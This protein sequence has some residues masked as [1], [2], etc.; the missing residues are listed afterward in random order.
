MRDRVRKGRVFLLF[1]GLMLLI[2]CGRADAEENSQGSD[3]M[4]GVS[5]IHFLDEKTT[6]AGSDNKM[7][8]LH[9]VLQFQLKELTIPEGMTAGAGNVF[10]CADGYRRIHNF[11]R[12]RRG[13]P[14]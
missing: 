5:E 11:L 9:A 14:R 7:D 4:R 13:E 10:L 6:A 3:A 1:L 2:G 8:D 12:V